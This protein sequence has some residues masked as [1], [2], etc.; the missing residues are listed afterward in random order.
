M[1]FADTKQKFQ[2][3]FTQQWAIFWGR[4]INLEEYNWLIGPFGNLNG[5]GRDY[6]SQLAK[7]ENLIILKSQN[8]Q[9]LL[10]SFEELHLPKNE[11]SNIPNPIIDFYE[12]TSDYNLQLAINWNPI[13]RVIG[14]L[15]NKLFSHRINQLNIPTSAIAGNESLNS[16]IIQLYNAETNELKYTIWMRSLKSSNQ[17]I[18]L[19]VYGTCILPSG[20]TCIKAVFPLPNGN[21]TIIMTPRVEKNG[22]FIL[23][24]SGSKVGDAGFYFLLNDE[25]K[26]IWTQYIRSFRDRLVLKIDNNNIIA[27]Q[28][29]TL[30]HFNV[31]K[32]SYII[33]RKV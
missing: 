16:E 3:W 2:D 18:Y 24:G 30:W 20:K 27:E 14:I 11:R 7:T 15:V 10:S 9:G 6:I 12:R 19:G 33:N 26:E 21:A 29:L 28:T 8:Y 25:K 4:K 31:L 13:F 5:I 23:D 32:F 17:V 22:T 1:Y